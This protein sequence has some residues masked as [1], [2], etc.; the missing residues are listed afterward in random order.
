MGAHDGLLLRDATIDLTDEVL[1]EVMGPR[2]IAYE[3]LVAGLKD[4]DIDLTW[5]FYK[6][7]ASWLAKAP[8]VWTG[9]R[10]GTRE[11]NTLWLSVWEDFFKVA[12]YFKDTERHEVLAQDISDETRKV[13]SQG[14][15]MGKMNTFPVEFDI[16][17]AK[18]PTD[19][20]TLIAYKKTLAK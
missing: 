9:P 4:L 13:V 1:S 11:Y 20:L 16:D 6:D 8:Y 3:Q 10:G 7:G 12:V 2:F 15:R 5:Q 18:L 19:L 14:K 17:S